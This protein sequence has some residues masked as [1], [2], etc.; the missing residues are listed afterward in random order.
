MCASDDEIRV[1]VELAVVVVQLAD[2]LVSRGVGEDGM[3][4]AVVERSGAQRQKQAVFKRCES[5]KDGPRRPDAAGADSTLD[6][7]P[8]CPLCRALASTQR[9]LQEQAFPSYGVYSP[10]L[11]RRWRPCPFWRRP[12]VFRSYGRY[13]RWPRPKGCRRWRTTCLRTAA[14]TVWPPMRPSATRRWPNGASGWDS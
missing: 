14:A 11:G 12:F 8:G 9:I 4:R 5:W 6:S 7:H 2:D 1:Q 3:W 10:S 13:P